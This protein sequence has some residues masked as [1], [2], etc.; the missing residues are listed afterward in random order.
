[1]GEIDEAAIK[2]T[3]RQEWSIQIGLDTASHIKVSGRVGEDHVVVEMHDPKS[4][5][6]AGPQRV[7]MGMTLNTL[8]ELMIKVEHNAGR[9]VVQ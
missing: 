2:T 9:Q 1:M 6:E 4:D 3:F 5:D 8:R 7:Y